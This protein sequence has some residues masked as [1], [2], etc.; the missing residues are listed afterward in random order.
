MTFWQFYDEV[1]S[2]VT[3]QEK[4]Y[5]SLNFRLIYIYII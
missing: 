2:Y 4:V 3:I 5:F 1:I